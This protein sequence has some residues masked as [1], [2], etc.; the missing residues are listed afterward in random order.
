MYKINVIDSCIWERFCEGITRHLG[1]LWKERKGNGS[2]RWFW[3][4]QCHMFPRW[5]LQRLNVYHCCGC[6]D[7]LCAW[8][9]H[10]H[11]LPPCI[12]RRISHG[13]LSISPNLTRFILFNCLSIHTDHGLNLS[14]SYLPGEDCHGTTTCLCE[15]LLCVLCRKPWQPAVW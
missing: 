8:R 12:F 11:P 13:G 3:H 14:I 6:L 4:N 9:L 2:H 7:F 1:A 15:L 10:R 5:R